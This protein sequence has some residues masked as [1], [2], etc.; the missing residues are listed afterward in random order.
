[1]TASTPSAFPRELLT[2]PAQVRLAYFTALTIGHPLLLQAY[3]D[4]IAAIRDAAPGSLILLSGPSGVGKTTL[5]GRVAQ[6]LHALRRPEMDADPAH[7]P[8]VRVE[9]I[10]P[11]AGSFNWKDYFRRLLLALD[12]P[13]VDHKLAPHLWEAPASAQRPVVTAV[14]AVSARLRAASEK[15]LV[16]RRPC[17]VLLDEAQHLAIV[18]SGRKLLDQLNTIKSVATTTRTTHVLSGTDELLVFRNLRGQLCRR[19]ID[20]HFPRYRAEWP[21]HQQAF[22]NVLWTFQHH[23]PLE[24]TPDLVQQWDYFYERSIGCVGVLKDWLARALARA[25]D[26]GGTQLTRRQLDRHA[27][28]IA[29]CQKMLAE[30]LEGERMVGETQDARRVLRC[31]LGLDQGAHAPRSRHGTTDD[32][33]RTARGSP[34]PVGTRRPVRDT[35]GGQ[36]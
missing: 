17:A 21:D 24:D 29:Q 28:L 23:L 15:A 12:E 25:L 8:V 6:R 27:L 19:S 35:V 18:G 2:A 10:A 32:H 22:C 5:L 7:V 13:L 30:A 16:H 3:D 11:E 31:Q 20:I 33:A 34:R 1:M 14:R 26:E 9:A 4:L 36:D